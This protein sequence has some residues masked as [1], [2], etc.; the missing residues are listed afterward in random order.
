MKTAAVAKKTVFLLPAVLLVPLCV[1]WANGALAME[2]EAQARS[3]A[4]EG[5]SSRKEYSSLTGMVTMVGRDAMEQL[6]GFFAP[7]P[8]TVEPFI[9]LDEFSRRQRVS[10]LG[11]TLAEQ[12]AAVIGNESPVVWRP[13]AAGEGEQRV[14][15]VLQEVA[16]YLRIH[17]I[18]ANSRG[19]R[20]NYVLN[21]EMSEP[22]YRALHNY[23]Y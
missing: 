12:V 15:G 16:G 6:H 17:I 22:V 10:L 1:F 19:E 5:A 3:S 7:V 13:A 14:S 11:V 9:V 23:I 4:S 8:V 21:V 18:A 2:K 20:R